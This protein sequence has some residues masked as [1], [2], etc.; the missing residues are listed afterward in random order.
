MIGQW[1]GPALNTSGEAEN[2]IGAVDLARISAALNTW[3][4]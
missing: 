2:A 3:F 1:R 4:Q